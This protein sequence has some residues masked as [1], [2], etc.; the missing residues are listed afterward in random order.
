MSR[1]VP[2]LLFSWLT[3]A[4]G[5]TWHLLVT[6]I[7]SPPE[8]L[9]VA[10]NEFTLEEIDAQASEAMGGTHIIINVGDGSPFKIEHPMFRSQETEDALA[11]LEESDVEDIARVLLGDAEYERFVKAG[12][13][14]QHVNRV[15][16]L[17]GKR[18]MDEAQGRPTRSK[19]SSGRS[20]RQSKRR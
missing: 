17:V 20:Q 12:G 4:I 15:L 10:T 3:N 6:P 1:N 5:R 16:V 2:S 9:T 7:G 18:M 11:D 13:T 8:R 14:A 19:K